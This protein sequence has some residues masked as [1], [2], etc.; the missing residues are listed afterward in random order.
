MS[1]NIVG[2]KPAHIQRRS[3]RLTAYA[4]LAPNFIGFIVFTLIP[5]IVACGLCFVKWDFANPME[6]VGLKNFIKLFRDDGFQISL[7]N[8]I[9]FTVVSVPLTI[10]VSLLLALL[11]HQKLKGIKLFRTLFFFPYISSMVA[12][13]VVW[14]MLYHPTMGPIN[15]FLRLV[16][17]HNPPGWTSSVV[18]ALPA[19][20]LMCV[21][22][23]V[24]YYMIIYVAGLQSIPEYLYEA[25]TIDGASSWQ[26]FRYI[27]L[28]MLTPSTF[29]ICVLVIINS[30]KIFDPIMI[31]TDGG[32]GRATHT[33]VYY[34]YYQA[35]TLFKFGYAS[36]ISMALLVIVLISTII[37][38]QLES[39]WV[40]YESM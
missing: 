13:A 17:I 35:F 12:V 18:W 26:R 10:I 1:T 37:Q 2:V 24:G 23:Q 21:W 39:K 29:F 11:V 40:N 4:F 5:I 36:A 7:W 34:I 9:Y 15:Q 27:T 3:N 32:P 14:N 20:M 16:G 6:F 38:F 31:M 28:P 19:V 22:K 25:A 30:L 33:L 8:T